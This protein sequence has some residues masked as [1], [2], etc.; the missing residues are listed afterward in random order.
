M[1][2]SGGSVIGKLIEVFKEAGFELDRER[3]EKFK[4]YLELLLRWK[5][6]HNLTSAKTEEEIIRRHFLDSLSLVQCFRDLKVRWK[7][8]RIADVGSGAGFPGCPLKIYLSDFNLYLIESSHKRCAFLQHLRAITGEDWEV[9]CKRAEEVE[10]K[11]DIVVTRALGRFEDITEIL[12]R[13]SEELVFVMKGRELDQR[14]I[15]S[16]GYSPYRVNIPGLP[17]YF[18]LY[19]RLS[20]PSH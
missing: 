15:S 12:E 11:F 17:E 2:S 10:E 20:P 18:I 8:K 6:K 19:K 14:W 13:L 5:R 16:L 3:E 7:G 1:R 4:L 9:I